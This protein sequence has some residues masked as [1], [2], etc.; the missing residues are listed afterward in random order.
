MS[1]SPWKD[2][3]EAFESMFDESVVI[4]H[5]GERQTLKAAVFIDNTGDALTDAGM[6]S[7]REDIQIVC[8][9]KDWAYVQKLR[10]GDTVRRSEI[11]GVTYKVSEVKNDYLMGW[12]IYARSV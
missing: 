6:D 2:F 3:D 10:R 7:D 1:V 8:E 4:T 9:K 5:E 11:N 12:C